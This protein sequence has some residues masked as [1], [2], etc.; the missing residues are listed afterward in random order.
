MLFSLTMFPIGEGESLCRPVAGVIDELDRAGLK[1]QVTGMD[2][3]LEG[4]WDEVMP[5]IRRAEE[6]MRAQYGRV[7]MTLAIDDRTG[8]RNR[9]HGAVA[10]VERE[11]SRDIEHV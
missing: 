5:V 3:I 9:L 6:R 2:T 1:Y 7:Y 10:D 11:L 4:E 8:A